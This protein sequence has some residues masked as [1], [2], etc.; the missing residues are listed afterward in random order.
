MAK[1]TRKTPRRQLADKP[2]RD[3]ITPLERKFASCYY[4]D[5]NDPG[6][7][8]A[9]AGSRL[10]TRAQLRDYASKMLKSP[11]VQ[12]ELR[13]IEALAH[14]PTQEALAEAGRNQ[15]KVARAAEKLDGTS[16]DASVAIVVARDVNTIVTRERLV[17]AVDRIMSIALMEQPV[18]TPPLAEGQ[19][20]PAA[21]YKFD[22]AMVLNCVKWLGAFQVIPHERA[23]GAGLGT[24]DSQATAGVTRG[25]MAALDEF[26]LQVKDAAAASTARRK[27]IDG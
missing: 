14:A 13:R 24:V 17:L 26:R 23:T 22:P 10:K 15:R 4:A 19:E 20:A 27:T 16:A 11:R 5:P 1:P 25:I 7:A 9:A 8:L 12:Q 6:A 2:N 3:R 21:V 18:P